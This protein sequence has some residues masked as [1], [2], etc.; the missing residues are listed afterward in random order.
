MLDIRISPSSLA[1]VRRLRQDAASVFRELRNRAK[2]LREV[3]ERQINR[4]AVNFDSQGAI[5][6][7]W[8]AL[9]PRW[10]G[11]NETVSD[12]PM[13][14]R[15]GRLQSWFHKS[16]KKGVVSNQ[17]VTWNFAATG[18]KD[19]SYAVFHDLGSRNVPANSYNP[20]RRLWD[21]NDEDEEAIADIMD[22]W[23]DRIL[24]AYF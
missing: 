4:W 6:G 8:P 1:Q 13:L 12:G 15:S 5:Y 2:P 21:L 22:D 3:K 9:R 7:P 10:A 19:G 16:N 18:N 11:T 23:A 24:S 17:A 14:V 20:S